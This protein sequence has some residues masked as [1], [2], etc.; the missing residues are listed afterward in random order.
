MAVTFPRIV[1][2]LVGISE[3]LVRTSMRSS[4]GPTGSACV[5]IVTV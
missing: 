5:L 2:V 1:M 4:N 3:S